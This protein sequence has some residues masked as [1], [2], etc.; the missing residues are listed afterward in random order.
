MQARSPNVAA[1]AALPC[2]LL[3]LHGCRPATL[4]DDAVA[5]FATFQ[6]ALFAGDRARLRTALASESRQVV[7]SLPLGDRLSAKARLEVL[8]VRSQPPVLHVEVVDPNE[9]GR[10]STYVLVREEGE[11]RVDLV[12]TSALQRTPG[13]G[14]SRPSWRFEPGRLSP[15]QIRTAEAAVQRM[16]SPPQSR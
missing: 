2:V 6:D 12:A 7:D 3:A 1:C 15:D 4:E 11:L 13:T 16:G 5:A 9:N 10:H 8:S 14:K